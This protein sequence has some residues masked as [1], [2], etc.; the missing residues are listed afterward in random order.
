[1][2]L[3]KQSYGIIIYSPQH[4][5]VYLDIHVCSTTMDLIDVEES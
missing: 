1:M 4:I 2:I 3:Y 5:Y